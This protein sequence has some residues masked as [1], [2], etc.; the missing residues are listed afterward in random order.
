MNWC[1]F[2]AVLGEKLLQN[3]QSFRNFSF[4]GYKEAALSLIWHKFWFYMEK[5]SVNADADVSKV[6]HSVSPNP[7]RCPAKRGKDIAMIVI[8]IFCVQMDACGTIFV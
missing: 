6:Y 1:D 4:W 2:V 7:V 3:N 8:A 5:G